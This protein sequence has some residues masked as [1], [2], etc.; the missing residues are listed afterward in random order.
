ML[1]KEFSKLRIQNK[2]LGKKHK[3]LLFFCGIFF[4]LLLF[5][6]LLKHFRLLNKHFKKIFHLKVTL[7]WSYEKLN[8]LTIKKSSLLFN[9]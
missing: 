8:T 4:L 5:L 2:F 6:Y 9:T 7:K 3:L 1:L